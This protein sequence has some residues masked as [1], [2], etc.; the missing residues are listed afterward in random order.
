MKKVHL[1]TDPSTT[2]Y[3]AFVDPE[4]VKLIDMWG[5]SHRQFCA[6]SL[7]SEQ[8]P[9]WLH[10]IT[11]ADALLKLHGYASAYDLRQQRYFFFSLNHAPAVIR[12]YVPY[13]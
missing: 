11:N 8:A 7:G 2:D 1:S 13:I 4:V 5:Y 12:I 9:L 10:I 6:C 3:R